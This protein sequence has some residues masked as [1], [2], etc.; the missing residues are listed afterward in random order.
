MK[1]ATLGG[2]AP[3]FTSTARRPRAPAPVIDK[4]TIVPVAACAFALIVS[5]L[6]AFFN[7]TDEQ[8]M[9]TAGEARLENRVFWPAMAVISI[10]LAAQNFSRLGKVTRAPHIICLV[11]YLSFAGASVLW[12]FSPESAFVRFVQQVMIVTS[13][14]LPA[15]LA[16]RAADMVRSLYL[17]FAFALVVNLFFVFNGSVTIVTYGAAL[18]NIGYEGYFS[19]KNYL[20]ECAAVAL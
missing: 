3:P 16:T 15:L 17:C 12:A 18:V 9:H 20:G 11:A 19:G 5:P 13:I 4:F 6:L 1:P 14:V 7:P 10:L 8:A 2:R